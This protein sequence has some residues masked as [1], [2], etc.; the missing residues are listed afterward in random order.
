MEERDTLTRTS[1][2]FGLATHCFAK[3]ALKMFDDMLVEGFQPNN[4]IFLRGLIACAHSGLVDKGLRCF[5][6]MR[7]GYGV[8]PEMKH[9]GCVVDL[10]ESECAVGEGVRVH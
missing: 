8:E 10:F 5:E 7:E 1:I 3:N 2:I 9:Y 6:S 4:V